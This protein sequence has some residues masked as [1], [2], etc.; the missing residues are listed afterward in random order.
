MTT[1]QWREE[2]DKRFCQNGFGGLM[3]NHRDGGKILR[4]EV[5]DFIESLLTQQRTAILN[6]IKGK[7]C[8]HCLC[9]NTYVQ[10]STDPINTGTL[11][12]VP[13]KQCCNCGIK[14]SLEDTST[15]ELTDKYEYKLNP[16]ISPVITKEETLKWRGWD[17]SGDR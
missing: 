14:K 17:E 16:K 8:E 10:T 9:I 5:M 11:I 12:K 3:P 15:K 1:N 6:E 13:H 7:G 2:F 4:K